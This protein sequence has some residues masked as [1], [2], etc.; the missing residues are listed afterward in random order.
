M[1]RAN[2]ELQG[3]SAME[4]F[5]RCVDAITNQGLLVILNHHMFDAAWCCDTIDGNGLW[6]TDKYST[7]DWL[8]GLTFL[9]ERYKDNPRVVAFDIRNEPRPWV[10]EGGTSILPWWGLETS[11]LNLFGYQVV[12]WRRAASR[13]AVAV[14]KGN[15]VAN[16]VIE[17]NWF[18]SNLAHVTDLP[19]MLAQGCLQSRVVYS[20]HEYSWYSTAYLVW[21]HLAG[22]FELFGFLRDIT[23][24]YGTEAEGRD[25]VQSTHPFT[26][27]PYDRFADMREEAGFYLQRDDIAPVWVSEFGGMRRGASKWHNNTMRFFKAMDASWCWWPLDPQKIP[28]DFDP[29]DPD[30]QLD[31][32]GLFNPPSRDYRS[33]VGWKLQDLVDLQAPSPDAPARVSVP[34]QCTFDPRANEEAANRATGG[35]EFLLSIHWTVYMALTTAI[36]VLLVLLRCIALCSCCLCVRTAWLGFTSG[37]MMWLPTWLRRMFVKDAENYAPLVHP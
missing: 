13:G 4:V 36:F 11:I 33:V 35:L 7:D 14:W 15:P 25:D 19:L 17:G 10:K 24:E 18:A 30:G 16:V 23:V 21:S 9:A 5:D 1:L 37:L 34:P 27:Q 20:L 32:Y 26:E 29:E 22:P 12:D 3:L 6:F 8:N 2:P 28:Q 31:L